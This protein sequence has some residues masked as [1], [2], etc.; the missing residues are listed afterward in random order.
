LKQALGHNGT[1]LMPGLCWEAVGREQPV[2]DVRS[3]PT[4]VGAIPEYFRR[5][6][7]TV[8][9]L[10]PTHSVCGQ[11][12]LTAELF[13]NHSMDTTPCGPNSPF[14]RLREFGGQV[15]MLGCGMLRN[16]S[17]HAVEEV[18]G[19]P[20]LFEAE[21]VEYTLIDH[22]GGCITAL[23]SRHGTFPQHFDRVRPRMIGQGLAE[24][25]VLEAACYLYDSRALWDTAMQMLQEDITCF[26][27]D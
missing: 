25:N 26:V 9:S 20:Y 27:K 12:P 15:L 19:A 11:G 2:F 10:H 22:N 1:L 5:M 3:T 6:E 13:S 7:G 23:H 16:T 8:R 21:P 17:V 18:A 14:N 4:C 24:G